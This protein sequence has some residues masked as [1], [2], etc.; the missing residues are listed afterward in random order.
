LLTNHHVVEG[1]TEVSV[2]D[3][4]GGLHDARVEARDPRNDL[5]VVGVKLPLTH[6]A[7]FRRLPI[8]SGEDVVAV[9]FPLRGLLAT[10][11][12]VSK[13]IV[14]A[15]A[16]L[17]NDTSQLQISAAVQP[18]NSGGPLLD[19]SGSVAGIVVA[20]LD[21]IAVANE[22]GDLPQNVNFAIKAEVATVFLR[23][24]GLEP[25]F[26]AEPAVPVPVPNAVETARQY[27]FVVRCDPPRRG[28][29]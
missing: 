14:S 29:Y 21:A 22:T 13:G 18:G 16:G 3:R 11:I 27:S 6:V 23:T 24:Y 20:T 9:G 12:N 25:G 19:T 1:C 5:A 4:M 10:D 7:S 26:T 28:A 2:M 8:R 15:T 17:R